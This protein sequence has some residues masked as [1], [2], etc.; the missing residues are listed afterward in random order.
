MMFIEMGYAMLMGSLLKQATLDAAS[1]ILSH[2]N[3]LNVTVHTSEVSFANLW[4]L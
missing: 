3:L 1:F 4:G 2:F